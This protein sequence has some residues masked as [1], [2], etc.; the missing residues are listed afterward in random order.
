MAMFPQDSSRSCFDHRDLNLSL[1]AHCRL[2][3][4]CHSELGYIVVFGAIPEVTEPSQISGSRMNAQCDTCSSVPGVESQ[5]FPCYKTS[6][7]YSHVL[8]VRQLCINGMPRLKH[9]TRGHL[10][11]PNPYPYIHNL[12]S[13]L[14]LTRVH[15]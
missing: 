8:E 15:N 14:V 5:W 1:F 6:S 12:R 2:G 4:Q 11:T 3:H 7:L 9:T 13:V 10:P